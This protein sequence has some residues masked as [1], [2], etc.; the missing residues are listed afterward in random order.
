MQLLPLQLCGK[1]QHCYLISKTHGKDWFRTKIVRNFGRT[2]LWP[3][4]SGVIFK[5]NFSCKLL[6]SG[7]DENN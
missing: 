2:I 7:R 1:L 3:S 6:G 4:L 5:G